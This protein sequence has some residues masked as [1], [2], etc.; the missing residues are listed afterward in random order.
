MT[1]KYQATLLCLEALGNFEEA[2]HTQAARCCRQL[3][4]RL[5]PLPSELLALFLG[6]AFLERALVR[7]EVT[8]LLDF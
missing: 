3:P 7:R 5:L 2:Y 4:W 6:L 1:E 8:S